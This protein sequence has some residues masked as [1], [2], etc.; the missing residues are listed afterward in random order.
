MILSYF[1]MSIW[2]P[3]DQNEF[4]VPTNQP[5]GEVVS[6]TMHSSTAAQPTATLLDTPNADNLLSL[7]ELECAEEPTVIQNQVH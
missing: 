3:E 2:K 6:L 7:R 4:P 5:P 1:K